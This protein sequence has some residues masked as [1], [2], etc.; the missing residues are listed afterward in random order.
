MGTFDQGG[1]DG[2]TG[3]VDLGYFTAGVANEAHGLFGSLS[4]AS[5]GMPMAAQ[6]QPQG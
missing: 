5:A 2:Q 3:F 6:P 4:P 1:D